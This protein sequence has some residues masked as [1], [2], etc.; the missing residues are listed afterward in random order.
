MQCLHKNKAML[1]HTAELLFFVTIPEVF[2]FIVSVIVTAYV[3][4][5][6]HLKELQKIQCLPFLKS[7]L[8][9]LTF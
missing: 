7:V 8:Q 9:C 4:Q 6:E 1:M 3:F 5:Y 2:M